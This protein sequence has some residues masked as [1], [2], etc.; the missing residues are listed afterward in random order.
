MKLQQDLD[1]DPKT[2]QFINNELANGMLSRKM[3]EPWADIYKS[4]LVD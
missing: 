3:R 1:W 2:E 4:L